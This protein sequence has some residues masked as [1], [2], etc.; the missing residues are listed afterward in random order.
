[1]ENAQGCQLLR[2]SYLAA[3][4]YKFK[5]PTGIFPTALLVPSACL[6]G[7]A[8]AAELAYGQRAIGPIP[9]NSTLLFEV[10]LLAKK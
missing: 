6:H 7:T 9:P 10:E 2:C 1:M 3:W 5:R 8:A 4:D